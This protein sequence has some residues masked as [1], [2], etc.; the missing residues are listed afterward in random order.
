MDLIAPLVKTGFISEALNLWLA[1][2]IGFI[3]GFALHHGGFTD[4]RK[5]GAVFYFKDVDVP[6][7]MFSAIV[8]AMLGLWGL[9]LVGFIDTEIFYFL[10]TYLLPVAVGGILF[11]VGMVVGGFCPGTAAA[12]IVTGK[13]DPLVFIVGFF[14]GSLVFGDF[15]PVW[16]H[17]F[18]SDYRGVW[19][20]NQLFGLEL[21][22]TILIMVII[23]IVGSMF[24]RMVQRIAW[25]GTFQPVTGW[26]LKVQIL[27]I[28][29]ALGLATVMA[30][31][32][33]SAFLPAE[34]GDAWYIVPKA[35]INTPLPGQ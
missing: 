4:S 23:A 35:T 14:I 27:L 16:G 32:P 10:P 20:L 1:V 34:A 8:T 29:V 15:F 5:I 28:L 9:S 13:I 6:I 2:P 25:P 19:H 31:Y 26:V 7:V 11:G 22:V 24:L 18:H 33:T 21:G 12:S 30:F 3:F 17:F